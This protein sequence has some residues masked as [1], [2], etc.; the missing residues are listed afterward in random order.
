[1][2]DAHTYSTAHITET[3]FSTPSKGETGWLHC[4]RSIVV[5]GVPHHLE[6]I[7]VAVTDGVQHAA[8]PQYE[9]DLTAIY[10]AV[11]AEGHMTP[12]TINGRTYVLVMT[13]FC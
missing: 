10:Q 11:G 9:E 3:D 2:N 7:E 5:L 4:D 12:V 8:D 13:P 6:A 1:M